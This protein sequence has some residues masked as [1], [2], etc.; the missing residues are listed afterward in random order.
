MLKIPLVRGKS[1]GFERD[2]ATFS[3]KYKNFP[4]ILNTAIVDTGCPF[5][6]LSETALRKTRIPYK[7]L[8]SMS[9]PV[10]VGPM[11]LELKDLGEC[12]LFFRD[13]DDKSVEPFRS[14]VYVG[15]ISNLKKNQFLAQEIPSFIGKDFFD[16]HDLSIIKKEGKSFICKIDI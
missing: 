14:Q 12:E 5:I 6:I 8:P 10:Q 13:E 9:K 11:V 2:I 3:V 15:V 4:R 1:L 7:N 16:K